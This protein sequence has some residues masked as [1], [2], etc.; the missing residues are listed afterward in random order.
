MDFFD[1][2]LFAVLQVE[3]AD[4][5][6]K[7]LHPITAILDV[8]SNGGIIFEE[9]NEDTIEWYKGKLYKA[10]IESA[11]LKSNIAANATVG[12]HAELLSSGT[13]NVAIGTRRNVDRGEKGPQI[14]LRIIIDDKR[15]GWH[16]VHKNDMFLYGAEYITHIKLDDGTLLEVE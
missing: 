14:R 6:L 9:T 2:L 4:T 12:Y 7:S 8:F 16:K 1:I 13:N 3:K 10:E 15:N 11:A 5:W